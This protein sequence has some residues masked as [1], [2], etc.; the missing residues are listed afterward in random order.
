MSELT[1]TVKRQ[2]SA[3]EHRAKSPSVKFETPPR[4]GEDPGRGGAGGA[5]ASPSAVQVDDFLAKLEEHIRVVDSDSGGSSQSPCPASTV[6]SITS[7]PQGWDKVDNGVRE[8][9]EQLQE[10]V[11][12]PK[13][14]GVLKVTA[15]LKSV[16]TRR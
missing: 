6:S 15:Y 8:T 14:S 3:A 11:R 13:D 12:N 5:V 4:A 9:L 16:I 10:E 1:D 7:T 2:G